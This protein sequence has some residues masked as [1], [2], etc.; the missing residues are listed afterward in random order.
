MGARTAWTG[1]ATG[2]CKYGDHRRQAWAASPRLVD[3]AAQIVRSDRLQEVFGCFLRPASLT[4][5]D[6]LSWC[7]ARAVPTGGADRAQK[8]DRAGAR[9]PSVP[10]TRG[11]GTLKC[12]PRG[13]NQ[14]FVPR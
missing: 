1:P 4:T 9:P 7:S 14:S 3:Q 13:L 11:D 6:S 5:D 12:T 8:S 10:D 2:P